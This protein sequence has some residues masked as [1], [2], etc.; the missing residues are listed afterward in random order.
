MIAL[1]ISRTASPSV[2]TASKQGLPFAA[3]V[4][5]KK[6]SGATLGKSRL[7]NYH[8]AK[9]VHFSINRRLMNMVLPF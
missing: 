8:Q 3:R 5:R 7:L 2:I 9:I 6:K 4:L 1:K